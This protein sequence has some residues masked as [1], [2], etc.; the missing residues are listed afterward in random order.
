MAL[1]K[2]SGDFIKAGSVT[3]AHLHSSHGITTSHLTEGDKLFFT[4]A[5]VDSRIGSLSSSDLSEGTN[6]YYTDAR[7]RAAISGTG[8]LSYNSTTGVMSFTMPAQNTSNITEGSNLYY[9]DARADARIAAADTGDLSEGTNLY[10][11]DAR[12]DARIT[13]AS[14]SDLSEGTNLYYTDARADARVALIVDSAPG[15]LNTLN[16]LAAALGD[17]ASFSTTVTN[18]IATKMPLAGGTFSGQVIFPYAATTKPV[19]PNGFISRNDLTDTSTFHDI[20]GISE[21]YYPSSPTS[22]DK[23]GIQWLGTPNDIAFVGGG[24][25]VFTI[26]LDEGNITSAGTITATGNIT[27][28]NLSGTN[29]GDQ[30][31]PT[32]ASLGAVTLTGNQTI[33]GTK[34]FYNN[35][36]VISGSYGTIS[37]MDTTSGEDNFYLHANS[38]NFYILV[39][40]DATDAIDAG[41]ESPHPLQL[42]GDT[43]TAYVFG[44]ALN[45]SNWN[46]AYGWGDHGAAGYLTSSSTQGKYIRSDADDTASGIITLTKNTATGLGNNAFSHAKT[47]IGG[48]HF[49][50]G[51]GP[52]A[53]NGNQ[54]AITFQGGT[55]SQ[56]QA[57][58]Y[59]H[60]NNSQG[61]HMM[62]A[63]TDSYSTGPKAG[64]T[65]LNNGNVTIRGTVFASNFSGSSSGTNTGDQTLAS[66]GYTGATNANYITNNNQLTNGAAYITGVSVAS[67]G[68]V[69][70]IFNNQTRNHTTQN[71]FNDTSLRAGVNY[72]QGGTNGPTDTSGHQWYGFRMGLGNDYGTQTG[73]SSHYAQ[74][75]YIA[76][77][78]QG[79]NN[80]GGNFLWTRDMEGGNWGSWAKID[81]DRLQLASGYYVSQGDWGLRNTT[82]SGWIQL[83]PANTSHA[84]IYTN[85]DNFYFNAFIQVS[86]GSAMRQNDIRSKIFYDIDNTAYA[87]HGDGTSVLN[88][89]YISGSTSG[90]SL[91]L[92]PTSA[93]RVYNDSARASLV[94]NSTLYPHLYINA[95]AGTSNS[96]HGAAM[97]MTGNI[98]GGYRRWSMGWANWNPTVFTMGSYDNNSNPHYGCGGLM[99]VTT[100]GSRFWFNTSGSGQAHADWR[101]PIFYDSNDTGYY[102]NPNST[103]VLSLVNHQV[104]V[105]VNQSGSQSSAHGVSLYGTYNGGVPT[106]GML[107]TGTSSQGTHGAVTD[108]WATFFTMNNNNARGWIFRKVGSTNTASIS[109]AGVATFDGSVRSP[110]YYDSNNTG[111]Y[112]NHADTSNFNIVHSQ[113][114]RTAGHLIVGA[115]SDVSGSSGTTSGAITFS[116]DSA[117]SVD[118]YSIKTTKENYGGNYNKL[119]LAFHTGIRLGA[120]P[121]YGGVRFYSDQTMGTEI[122]AVGKSGNYVQAANSLRAPI[123]YDS[124]NTAYY[125]DPAGTGILNAATINYINYKNSNFRVGNSTTMNAITSGGQNV[126]FGP[127]ALGA[128]NTGTR[129]FAYGYAALFSLTSGANNIAMGDATGYNVTT[130]SNNLLF[131]ISAGRTG[132]QSPQSIAGVTSHNHQIHMGNESH[133][134]ARIQISWTVN[135]DARDKTDITP[136][137]IGLD[138]VKQLNP[139]TYRW[140]K[141]SDYE[142]RTPDGTN[143]LP[144]LTLGFLAQEVEVVEKS[145][146]YDVANQT[147]LVVDRIPE[148]D[149]YGI[150]YEKMVP[151]LTKAIQEQQTIIDD[152]KSRLETLENN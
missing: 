29:T 146:G 66:L 124:A 120:H 105:G 63:T 91:Q 138:F 69:E 95:T 111:Y 15:T 128:C 99:G 44:S 11:T 27:G 127:E 119:D 48:L 52:G 34:T 100:W 56:A 65:L 53:N 77:K 109:A 92:G 76:R 55:A 54:A 71:N 72:F 7:A 40:R 41:Y 98:S 131:G 108:G 129:N 86:G 126:A 35:S 85:L 28:A 67:V 134:T 73:S 75:W 102:L 78:N 103:S 93:T 38:N 89:A 84:H 118:H 33:S 57:G 37:F 106:Y 20:W 135:S 94:I 26:S 112:A 23:W 113:Q 125:S 2:V 90:W 1:T 13:A 132:Y 16:E 32:A 152:L 122:F 45:I 83:G 117:D 36:I 50:N 5:R 143:K 42:E 151:I 123:F 62:F 47:V 97:T 31:L 70:N 25:N 140:D 101:A 87:F 30:T 60:N 4:N 59:V 74:E 9:T 150:T 148:Q 18:S 19:L 68:T 58:I 79:G 21:R 49:A 142:D 139:V 43:N 147:N 80:T 8:S 10:Y 61:T 141:R 121:N 3:Q 24:S 136:I 144:E 110:I 114:L 82:P 14:T 116:G 39:D 104:G 149:H 145:F 88:Q 81:T 137:D 133:T 12:A 130:G 115:N 22:G 17:D 51:N 6:L 64:I 96:N 46:T 107:F